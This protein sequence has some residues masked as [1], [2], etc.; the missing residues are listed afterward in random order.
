MSVF[1]QSVYAKELTDVLGIGVTIDAGTGALV[2]VTGVTIRRV[3]AAPTQV[4]NAGSMALRTNGTVYVTTGAGVWFPVGGGSG[5]NLPDD[6]SGIWGTNAPGQVSSTY[7][8]ASNRFDLSGDSYT[9]AT[10]PGQGSAIRVETGTNNVTGA[11]VGTGSANIEIRTGATSVTDAGG[12]AGPSG[13][14]LIT[15]GAS[16]SAAGISGNS[17]PI[18][19][20]T[21]N[22]ED[23]NSGG[24]L[25]QTGT[26]AGTRGVLKINSATVDFSTQAVSFTLL[27]GNATALRIGTLGVPA[28]IT[29]NTAGATEVVTFSESALSNLAIG[30]RAAS[31]G[32]VDAGFWIRIPYLSAAGGPTDTALPARTGGWRAV[33]GYI[34]SGGASAGTVTVQT[35]GGAATVSDAMVP[36]VLGAGGITRMALVQNNTFAGGAIVR[37]A[38]AGGAPS[39]EAFLRLEPL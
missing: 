37:I 21:G 23:G 12:T 9:S 4:D 32:A 10:A 31:N 7:V 8:S 3:T 24:I 13:S 16:T 36:S 19:L 22:S 26:A 17:S 33:D 25:L 14:I 1:T 29:V 27:D 15:T 34:V 20:I 18:S 30:S 38:P 2:T 6:V 39:G 11:I 5:W 28:V 35:A